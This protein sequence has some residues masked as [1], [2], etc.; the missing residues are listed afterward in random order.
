D[1]IEAISSKSAELSQVMMKMGEAAY[2]A[3]SDAE[4]DG[5]ADPKSD[6]E[7][8]VDAEFEEVDAEVDNKKKASK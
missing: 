5:S 3:D 7:T 4:T 8:V 6:D 2:Q 1:D